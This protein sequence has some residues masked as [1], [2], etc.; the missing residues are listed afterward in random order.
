MKI[1]GRW[2]K[3]KERG[4]GEPGQRPQ[5]TAKPEREAEKPLAKRPLS[6]EM[7]RAKKMAL[8][9]AEWKPFV[10]ACRAN[11]LK[12]PAKAFLDFYAMVKDNPKIRALEVRVEGQVEEKGGRFNRTGFYAGL[13]IKQME[14]G[15]A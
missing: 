15:K 11:G 1:F 10:E 7:D 9:A 4:E 14:R 13:F 6:T 3:L 8:E 2:R 5:P 12:D